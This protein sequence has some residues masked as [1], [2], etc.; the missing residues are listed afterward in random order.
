MPRSAVLAFRS[1][2]LVPRPSRAGARRAGLPPSLALCAANWACSHGRAHSACGPPLLR[3]RGE[4][5]GK[6]QL[7]DVSA[8]LSCRHGACG[9]RVFPPGGGGYR[10]GATGPGVQL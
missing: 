4:A 10:L 3:R 8:A 7:D 9:G 6:P 1:C 5:L 2:L